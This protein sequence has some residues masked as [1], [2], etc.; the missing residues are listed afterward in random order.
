MQFVQPHTARTYIFCRAR[1]RNRNSRYLYRSRDGAKSWNKLAGI[2]KSRLWP[3]CAVLNDNT[4]MVAGGTNRTGREV[5]NKTANKWA[6]DQF[7]MQTRRYNFDLFVVYS[8]GQIH[9]L[10]DLIVHLLL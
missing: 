7:V 6:M 5:F 1:P 8:N 9:I 10:F 3:T 4:I 2:E